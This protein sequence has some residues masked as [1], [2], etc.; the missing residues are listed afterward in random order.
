MHFSG[1][2]VPAVPSQALFAFRGVDATAEPEDVAGRCA[3]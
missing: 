2:Q 3:A 1:P